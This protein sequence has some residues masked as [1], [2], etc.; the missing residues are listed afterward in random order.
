VIARRRVA[1]LRLCALLRSIE[2]D[3]D[4]FVAVRALNLGILKEVLSDEGHVLR[5][6]ALIKD[7][8]RRLKIERP[9]RSDALALRKQIKRHERAVARYHDQLFIWRCLGDGLAYAYISTFNIKHA[10]FE[11]T[12]PYAKQDAGFITGKSGLKYE[13]ALLLSAIQHRVPAVLCDIT[14]TIRYGDICLLGGD[15]PV[16]M[17]VKSR[18]G[19]LNQRGKRQAAR[20]AELEDFLKNDYAPGFRGVPEV[21]R[22]AYAIPHRDCI[23]DMNACIQAARADGWNV[24]CPERGLIYVAMF[25]KGPIEKILGHM[26]MT[27]PVIFMLNTDKREKTWAPY[28]PFVNSIR[29]LGDLY[30]FVAGNLFLIVIVDAA[31]MCDRLAMPGWRVSL[32]DLTDP[33]IL[34]E[35]IESGGKI[36]VSNQFIGRLGY[37]FMSL[38]WF[39]EHEKVQVLDMWGSMR[40]GQGA[41]VDIAEYDRA[42]ETYATIPRIYQTLGE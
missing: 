2:A 32:L 29:G 27:K 40:A 13:L 25:G 7:L 12:S 28:L 14:N 9:T 21:R 41:V 33:A 26:G 1:F 36:V 23:A 22:V 20:L 6:R 3:L 19:V 10:F 24:V 8:N 15:D 18:A 39:V 38:D 17:E 30:D 4:N 37:E 11:T 35:E 16:P 31:V 5:L 42:A 34:L